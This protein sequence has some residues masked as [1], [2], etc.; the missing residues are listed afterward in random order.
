MIEERE[1]APVLLR[2]TF[3]RAFNQSLNK[4]MLPSGLQGLTLGWD[5]SQS[6]NNATLPLGLQSMSSGKHFNQICEQKTC[7]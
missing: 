7:R 3:G 5:F 2:L 1:A 4:A 6:L